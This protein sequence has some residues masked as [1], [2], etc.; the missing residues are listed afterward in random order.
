MV[1]PDVVAGKVGI[2]TRCLERIRTVTRDDP[3][4]V[5]DID[6]EDIV[7][8][9]LQRAIQACIDLMTHILAEHNLGVPQ[10]SAEGFAVL[11][12]TGIIRPA[13]AAELRKM[14]GFRNLAVHE[15][16]EIDSRLLIEI[17]SHHLDDLRSFTSE[18]LQRF[19]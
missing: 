10:S 6:I 7:V 13:L 17:L 18:L 8:L 14:V 1:N 11:A 19:C 2:V 3:A 9:N 5:A 15:Y 4:T 16:D 12:T